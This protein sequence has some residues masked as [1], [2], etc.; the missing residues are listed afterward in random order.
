MR[1]TLLILA[2]AVCG[3]IVLVIALSSHNTPKKITVH[4]QN[5]VALGD[6]VS[7]GVGLEYYS[8][9]SACDRTNQSYP[10]IVSSSLNFNLS[11][12]SCSGATLS[13]GILGQ[14][15][16][17]DLMVSSQLNQLFEQSRPSLISLTIG[18]NDIQWTDIISKCYISVCGT[19]DDTAG[20]NA[21][22]TS[23]TS[24]MNLA[25]S[26]IQ[27]NY[28][29]NIPDVIVTGYHQV[30]PSNAGN[31]TDLKGIDPSEL[32]WGRLQQQNLNNAIQS[33]VATFP[34]AKFAAVNFDGHELCSSD[35]W[36]QGLNDSAPYH[37]T[38]A[39][40]QEYAKQVISI[41]R[42]FK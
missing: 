31:C 29:T 20:V 12:L 13:S 15:D 28:K 23:M 32:A 36:V 4:H 37:P 34:F 40:Q 42:S 2:L 19:A 26:K 10:N 22:L 3:I 17:N 39:G 8:D 5:Y 9:S 27:N 18:A 16:V 30:F 11:N 33:V 21:R 1:K 7:A 6:S 25:L 38:L 41:Y 24:N 14:Q 35:S